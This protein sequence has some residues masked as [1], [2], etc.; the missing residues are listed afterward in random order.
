MISTTD[1][2]QVA[3]YVNNLKGT[4]STGVISSARPPFPAASILSI[5]FT[6]ALARLASRPDSDI[7]LSAAAQS[8]RIYHQ[9]AIVALSAVLLSPGRRKRRR[10]QEYVDSLPQVG[11]Q[12]SSFGAERVTQLEQF[13]FGVNRT[14]NVNKVFVE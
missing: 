4:P 10:S 5:N 13:Y 11:E 1:I 12:F 7:R 14:V 2:I 9:V 3:D 8:W 6:N